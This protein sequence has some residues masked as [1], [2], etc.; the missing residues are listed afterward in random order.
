MR[1]KVEYAFYPFSRL[2]GSA[3]LD[4]SFLRKIRPIATET[5]GDFS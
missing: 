4:A 1:P 5:G 3:T 2:K